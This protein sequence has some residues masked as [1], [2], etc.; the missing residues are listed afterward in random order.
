M[1]LCFYFF[2]LLSRIMETT[3]ILYIYDYVGF[4]LNLLESKIFIIEVMDFIVP[5]YEFK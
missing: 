2:I 1:Y 5:L 4:K 3:K